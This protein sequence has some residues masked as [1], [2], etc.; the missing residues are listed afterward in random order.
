[1]GSPETRGV[2]LSR[3]RLGSRV[4][5]AG[6]GIGRAEDCRAAEGRL[7]L[8]NRSAESVNPQNFL[9]ACGAAGLGSSDLSPDVSGSAA[10][11]SVTYNAVIGSSMCYSD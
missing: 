6:E 3:G 5:E 11:T 10:A 2:L 1:M 8:Q 9:R 4:D 7:A